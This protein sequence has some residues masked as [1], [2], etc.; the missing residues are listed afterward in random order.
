M[1]V[2]ADFQDNDLPTVV[3]RAY[4]N[5]LIMSDG[6][7]YDTGKLKYNSKGMGFASLDFREQE[8]AVAI[9]KKSIN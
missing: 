6:T 2:W 8:R 4:R 5:G 3:Q 9:L 7:D 1:A